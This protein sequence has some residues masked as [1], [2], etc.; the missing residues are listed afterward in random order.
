MLPFQSWYDCGTKHFHPTM[1]VGWKWKTQLDWVIKPVLHDLVRRIRFWRIKSLEK[2][3]KCLYW[4]IS[5]ILFW[6]LLT[7]TG[8]YMIDWVGRISH[9]IWIW[10]YTYVSF[11]IHRSLFI[12]IGLFSYT[13]EWCMTCISH[14]QPIAERVAQNLQIISETFSTNQNSSHRI[15]DEYQVI[16][17]ESHE[18]PGTPGTKLKVFRNDLQIM[19]HPICNWLYIWMRIHTHSYV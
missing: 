6:N 15:Y 14:V 1:M 16:N 18:N 8:T 5:D 11:H 17:D 9:V 19:C 10:T 2:D 3:L 4:T 7:C 13:H 12:Y